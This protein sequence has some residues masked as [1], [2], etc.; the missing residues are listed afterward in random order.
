M[1][2]AALALA[3]AAVVVARDSVA[4]PDRYRNELGVDVANIITFLSKKNESYLLNYKRRLVG[5]HALR[6]ALN[7]EWST[8]KDGYKSVRARL[9]YERSL[10]PV[11]ACWQLYSG[12]DASFLRRASNFQQN[13]ATT[14]GLHP[15]IGVSYFVV[16]QFSISTEM[17]LNVYYTRYRN[18]ASFDPSDNT[19]AFD[20]NIGS[21]GM[22]VVSYHF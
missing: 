1:L 2:T 22:L 18:P 13:T 17:N 7:L 6:S 16:K 11:S 9:G 14:C 19:D 21:V 8:A 15:L 4:S 3:N 5:R 20:V 10:S 12:I